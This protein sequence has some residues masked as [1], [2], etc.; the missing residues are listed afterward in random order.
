MS[1][2]LKRKKIEESLVKHMSAD[3]YVGRPNNALNI[4]GHG[5]SRS[6]RVVIVIYRPISVKLVA[7]IVT[8]EYRPTIDGVERLT[9]LKS[10]A[11]T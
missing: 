3:M 6:C 11:I 1:G 5:S 9:E 8:E 4:A 7:Y 10:R 2:G